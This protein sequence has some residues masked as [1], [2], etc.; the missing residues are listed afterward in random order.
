MKCNS[1]LLLNN[2]NLRFQYEEY[3]DVVLT[4]TELNKIRFQDDEGDNEI[5]FLS[6]SIF[7]DNNNWFP[8]VESGNNDDGIKFKNNPFPM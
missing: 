3:E 7:I 8:N 4:A 2:N 6:S 5:Y 1:C